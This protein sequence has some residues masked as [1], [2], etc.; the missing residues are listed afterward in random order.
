[1]MWDLK[2]GGEEGVREV[3]ER[4]KVLN[5]LKIKFLK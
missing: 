3:K 4:K 5:E 2:Y 1:M